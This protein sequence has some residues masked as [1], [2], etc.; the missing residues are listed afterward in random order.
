[1][2]G[3]RTRITSIRFTPAERATVETVAALR[4]TT[5]SAWI[6]RLAM[7]AAAAEIEAARTVGRSYGRD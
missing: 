4:G 2:A 5:L 7:E 3:T 6:R 1:M